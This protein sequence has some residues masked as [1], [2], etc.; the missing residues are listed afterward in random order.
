MY[1]AVFHGNQ[2]A[3]PCCCELHSNA[4]GSVGWSTRTPPSTLHLW[5]RSRRQLLNGRPF[6]CQGCL[7][8]GKFGRQMSWR[9][10]ARALEDHWHVVGT[11]RDPWEELSPGPWTDAAQQPACRPMPTPVPQPP[12]ETCFQCSPGLDMASV[13]P[14]NL[15]FCPLFPP[16]AFFLLLLHCVIM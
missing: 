3:A 10:A 11:E 6:L 14:T 1:C 13:P 5:R 15:N 4:L 2:V 9:V 8:I 12:A 16:S 7:H